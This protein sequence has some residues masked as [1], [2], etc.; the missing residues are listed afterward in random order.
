MRFCVLFGFWLMRICAALTQNESMTSF[1]THFNGDT[2]GGR[3]KCKDDTY[4]EG[5]F[6]SLFGTIASLI[7]MDRDIDKFGQ[8]NK[9][10]FDYALA[11]GS[12]I[13]QQRNELIFAWDKDSDIYVI[14][15]SNLKQIEFEKFRQDLKNVLFNYI[16]NDINNNN[17]NKIDISHLKGANI[18]NINI[19]YTLLSLITEDNSKF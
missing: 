2:T 3:N 10:K 12:L 19:N 16:L 9:Y 8:N 17:N 18:S 1:Q 15:K 11:Y 6:V 4:L 13:A 14:F 5:I 7:L